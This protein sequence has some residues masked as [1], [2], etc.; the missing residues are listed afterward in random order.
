MSYLIIGASSGLGKDLAYYFAKKKNNLTICSRNIKDLKFIKHDLESKFK[1]S[2]QIL[3]IDFAKIENVKKKIISVP[4]IFKKID[5][6]LFPIGQMNNYDNIDTTP[7]NINNLFNSNFTSIAFLISSYMKNRKKGIIVGFGSVSAYLGREV[8]PY[9]S[10]S[11]RALESF[12][13]SLFFKNK[14]K[15]FFIQYYIL[16]YLNTRLADEKKLYLPKG[17]TKKLSQIVFNNR[18]KINKKI[19]FPIWWGLIVFILKIIPVKLVY[20]LIIYIN[21]LKN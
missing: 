15:K 14:K 6:I 13:E 2:V 11:K 17:S 8:N 9:Y 4:G 3:E 16:G 5:G 7:E 12:F 19:F 1:V 10:A 18:F 21:K 20:F